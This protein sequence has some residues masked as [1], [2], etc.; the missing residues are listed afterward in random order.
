MHCTQRLHTV[1][2][3]TTFTIAEPTTE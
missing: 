1:N 3:S 2:Q